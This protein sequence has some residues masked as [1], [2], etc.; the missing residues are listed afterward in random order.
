MLVT[1]LPTVLLPKV[2]KAYAEN[3][4][5]DAKN[6]LYKAYN[7]VWFL[8]TPL[9]FG[10]IGVAPVLVPVFF[11]QGYEPVVQVLP[12]M[13][14]LFIAMGLNQTSGTQF[15]IASGRQSEYTKR[16]IFGGIVNIAINALFI[17]SL[18]ATGA[19]IGSVL[20]EIVIMIT[21]FVYINKE[22]H[23]SVKRVFATSKKYIIAGICMLIFLNILQKNMDKSV[24]CLLI[25]IVFGGICYF[26]VLL[27]EKE[28]IVMYAINMILKKMKG[29]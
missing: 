10:T 22:K 11:G 27:I 14:L 16:I 24:L 12:V 5:E 7:F 21:E 8:G 29:K 9:M 20:G 13:S 26:G 23:F 1:A 28:K 15:F 4:L 25:S 6:Y 17:P 2:S 3:R 19:A 18:G